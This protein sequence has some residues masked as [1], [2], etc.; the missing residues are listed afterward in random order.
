MQLGSIG[1]SWRVVVRG[2]VKLTRGI[3]GVVVLLEGEI[4]EDRVPTYNCGVG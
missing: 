4:R 1:W 2:L 3:L